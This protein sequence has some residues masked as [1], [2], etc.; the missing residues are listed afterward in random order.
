MEP[1]RE[2]DALSLFL[3]LDGLDLKSDLDRVADHGAAVIEEFGPH[4]AE[5][6]AYSLRLLMN[7]SIGSA[8]MVKNCTVPRDPSS[9][10]ILAIA[11]LL[12]A[13]TTLTKS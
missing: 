3:F 9:T 1:E 4:Q 8:G 6:L 10:E 2:A 5:V 13:S 7:S 12:G 11:L